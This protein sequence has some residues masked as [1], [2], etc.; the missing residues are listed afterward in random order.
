M[1][2]FFEDLNVGM[3]YTTARR[4]ITEADVVNFAGVSGDFNALHMDE[5]FAA[6]E[7][8][9]GQRIA[10]GLL[11][12]AVST[13]LRSGVDEWPVVAYLECTRRFSRPVL[14]G[15]TVNVVYE[16][17]ELRP[18]R[19]RPSLGVVTMT[20]STRNQRDEEVQGGTDVVM[21]ARRVGHENASAAGGNG[22]ERAGGDGHA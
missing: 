15:D 2:V 12:T 7:T 5:V 22:Q 18:S 20:V 1:T 11:I 14:I 16:L 9:Y 19:S 3:T 8:P 10:H 4:T 13:G 6:T 17:T 21:V